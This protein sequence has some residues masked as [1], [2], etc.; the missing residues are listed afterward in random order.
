MPDMSEWMGGFAE[1]IAGMNESVMNQQKDF[2][3]QQKQEQMKMLAREAGQ[4][5]KNRQRAG[6]SSGAAYEDP[7]AYT[8]ELG[9]T[10]EELVAALKEYGGENGW[11][12]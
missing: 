6:L 1:M 9:T 2:R 11:T 8:N 12:V 4:A 5:R 10:Y 3:N 7:N